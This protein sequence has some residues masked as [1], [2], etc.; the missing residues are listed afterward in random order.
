MDKL[1]SLI[2][3]LTCISCGCQDNTVRLSTSV[4]ISKS[5]TISVDG[6]SDQGLTSGNRTIHIH[7]PPGYDNSTE[8]YP[9][10]YYHNGPPVFSD[11]DPDADPSASV[12]VDQVMDDLVIKGHITPAILVAIEPGPVGRNPDLIPV[13]DGAP[14]VGNIEGYH[15]FIATVLKPYIDSHFRTLTEPKN[16]GVVGFSLGGLGSLYLGYKHPETFGMIGCMSPSVWWNNGRILS[17]LKSGASPSVKPRFWFDCA[18]REGEHMWQGSIMAT[19][20]LIANGWDEQEQVAFH[21]DYEGAHDGNSWHN[22]TYPMF[23]YFLGKDRPQMT[24]IKVKSILDS[25]TE[26]I[27][28]LAMGEQPYVTLELQY[29]NGMYLNAVNEHYVITDPEVVS[30]DNSNYG[31]LANLSDGTTA[32]R[33]TYDGHH[34]SQILKAYGIGDIPEYQ[35]EPCV[36]ATMRPTVDGNT[37]EWKY[38]SD[39]YTQGNVNYSIGTCY[40][41]DYV[42][43]AVRI[44]KSDP[45]FLN[46]EW[47][48]WRQDGIEV[49]LDARP[50]PIRMNGQ[51]IGEFTRIMLLAASPGETPDKSVVFRRDML[52]SGT[53]VACCSTSD[54]FDF[55]AAI[56]TEYMNKMQK[57]NWREFRI[58]VCVNISNKDASNITKHWWYPDWRLSANIPGSGTFTREGK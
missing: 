39:A 30:V 33:T 42:Y 40:D 25:K 10:F 21:M 4:K 37:T 36:F 52:P 54:G 16:T 18:S 20:E 56:L 7:L 49:R 19:R 23:I 48:P 8:H 41:S 2:C 22:R 47:D 28:L 57:S 55:E 5:R 58:N 44:K 53:H 11:P 12:R 31:Y 38:M 35:K 45:L 13:E 1:I 14:S 34:T 46:P 15:K 9:V 32:I 24:G 3:I 50:D 17:L 27:S 29:S 26:P 51:G 6:F 43:I